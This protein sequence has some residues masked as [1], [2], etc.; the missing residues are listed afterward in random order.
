MT[1]IPTQND[2]RNYIGRAIEVTVRLLILFLLFGWCFAIISPFL[3]P[4]VW[5]V[6]IA[7][8]IYPLFTSL[9]LKLK[10]RGKLA[11]SILTLMMLLMV[12][13]PSWMLADSLVEGITHLREG[14]SD[15]RL[16]IPP[17]DD[18]VKDWPAIAKPVVDLWQ[19]ASENLQGAM[20]KFAPQIKQLGGLILS[21]LAGTGVG[22]LQFIASIILSGVFLHYAEAGGGTT[23]KV[24]RRLAGQQ[25]EEF[26]EISE[27]TIRNVVKG[28]LGVAVIQSMRAGLGFFV[29]GIPLAGLWTLLCLILAIIQIGPGPV[30]VGV[31]F[32]AFSTADTLT[33]SL[34]TAWLLVVG[35]SDN[36]LKPMLLGRGAQVPMLV[37]FL[38]SVGGFIANG[39]VGLFLGPVILSIGYKLFLVWVDDTA[40]HPVQVTE[41]VPSEESAVS[42]P[43]E[44]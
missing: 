23:R 31:I 41:S 10:G 36:I 19:L 40:H 30:F 22:V 18:R 27:T 37:V 15:G 13:I 7:I 35:I 4:V 39:F 1:G 24:F 33:A 43:P 8:S 32:Y 34:L 14:Y 2:S 11:A 6:I 16:V 12:I 26:A 9:K 3:S 29:A 21:L 44:N 17:P 5:G 25:G 38:G 42:T 20:E 28:I